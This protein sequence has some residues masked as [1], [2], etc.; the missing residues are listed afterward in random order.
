[1][2]DIELS[3][4]YI[5]TYTHTHMW[6]RKWRRRVHRW[7]TNKLTNLETLNL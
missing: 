2:I 7:Q 5:H 1:M 3:E 4:T 6:G